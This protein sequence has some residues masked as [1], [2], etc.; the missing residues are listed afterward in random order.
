MERVI[1]AHPDVNKVA[2]CPVPDERLGQKVA[3]IV[4]SISPTV[5]FAELAALCKRDLAGYKVPEIWVRVD[6]LPT[7]AMGKV[8]RTKLTE[9]A[10]PAADRTTE[11]SR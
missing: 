6:A 3:A 1:G 2:V 5:D 11:V 7:N 4:E 9:L 10:A 8:E